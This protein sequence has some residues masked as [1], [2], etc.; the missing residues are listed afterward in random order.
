MANL[1]IF[2]VKKTE[3][4]KSQLTNLLNLSDKI[5]QITFFQAIFL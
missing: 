4:L 3:C 1:Q 5:A 2:D